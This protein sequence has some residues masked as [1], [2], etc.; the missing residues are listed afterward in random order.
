MR[1]HL[2]SDAYLVEAS[3]VRYDQGT[4]HAERMSYCTDVRFP[5][6][7]L[8]NHLQMQHYQ[9]STRRR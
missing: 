2:R 6:T 4:R 1:T 7:N 8:P 9:T 5:L 3:K